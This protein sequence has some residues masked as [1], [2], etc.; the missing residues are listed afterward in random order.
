[1]R[2]GAAPS[3]GASSACHPRTNRTRRVP[4]PVLSG[5]AAPSS[6]ASSA[7]AR[8]PGRGGRRGAREAG[9]RGAGGPRGG[10]PARAPE[11]ARA[12]QVRDPWR[13]GGRREGADPA[14]PRLC[15]RAVCGPGP[16]PPRAPRPA[17][18][19]PR[20][21]PR[22]PRPAPRALRPAPRAPAPRAPRPAPRA[23]RPAPR[24]PRRAVGPDAR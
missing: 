9:R 13:R 6:G 11:G 17:P 21:A 15:A 19:A 8:T 7:C 16:P 23:P 12:A 10:W 1:M 24:A 3:S 20:P 2:W 14:A 5:H 18:R 22:A 4:H